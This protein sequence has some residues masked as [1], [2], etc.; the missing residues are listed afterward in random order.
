MTKHVDCLEAAALLRRAADLIV[1]LEAE[2]RALKLDNQQLTA[3][4]HRL[5]SRYESPEVRAGQDAGPY[6]HTEHVQDAL[7]V[8]VQFAVMPDEDGQLRAILMQPVPAKQA[9]MTVNA[10]EAAGDEE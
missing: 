4:V 2:N 5:R 6:F 10:A 8:Q 3:E 7:V 1:T 9:S